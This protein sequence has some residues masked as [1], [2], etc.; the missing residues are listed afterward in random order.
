[1]KNFFIPVITEELRF[2]IIWK[3]MLAHA[4]Y[5]FTLYKPQYITRADM[6]NSKQ[7]FTA[8]YVRDHNIDLLTAFQHSD[9]RPGLFKEKE[10]YLI[11]VSKEKFLVCNTDIYVK[12]NTIPITMKIHDTEVSL[13]NTIISSVNDLK[14]NI[15]KLHDR[16]IFSK[17]LQEPIITGPHIGNIHRDFTFE[18]QDTVIHGNTHVNCDCIVETENQVAAITSIDHLPEDFDSSQLFL[19]YR[20]LFDTFKHPTIQQSK[21]IISHILVC[22]KE[23]DEEYHIFMFYWKNPTQLTSVECAIHAVCNI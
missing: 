19:P 10:L 4:N 13:S 14:G 8:A 11:P 3:H 7:T 9:L 5:D 18:L 1:M 17:V 21:K 16:G 12:L 20:A 15:D 22:K 2:T 23:S 6:I